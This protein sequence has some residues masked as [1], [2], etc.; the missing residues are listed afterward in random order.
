LAE[1]EYGELMKR[2]NG[3]GNINID[4]PV[5]VSALVYLAN[6]FGPL[7]PQPEVAYEAVLN[8]VP[9][10]RLPAHPLVNSSAE[11]RLTH[12]RGQSL[13]DWIALRSGRIDTF[14]DGVAFPHTEQDVQTLMA[15][16]QKAGAKV[17]PYGGGTSVNGHINP[18]KSDAPVLTLSLEHMTRLLDLDKF[19]HTATFEAGITGPEL[20]KSLAKHGFTLGHF[21]QSHEYSTL[22]GW[23]ATRSSGQ[24]SYKYGRIEQLF[25]GG[26]IETPRGLIDLP[27]FPASAAGPEDR[28]SVV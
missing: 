10:S 11:A 13:P 20:E 3:W 24:Q 7:N 28:K 18:P 16:A 6:F 15:Y 2:W 14:P 19:G 23:I 17:I 1:N 27:H 25:A 4:Y 12:A 22:G 8:S 21:P 9:A 5:P 26:R